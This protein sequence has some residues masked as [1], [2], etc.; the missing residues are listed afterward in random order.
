[1]ET[2]QI[3]QSKRKMMDQIT[4]RF[5][6][7]LVIFGL[8]LARSKSRPVRVESWANFTRA[9]LQLYKDLKGREVIYSEFL[10]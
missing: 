1:M 5:E 9:W 4:T 7:M 6:N 2:N 10:T 3:G 8:Y